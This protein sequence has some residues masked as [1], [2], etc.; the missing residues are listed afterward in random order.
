MIIL[1][2]LKRYNGRTERELQELVIKVLYSLNHTLFRSA[3]LRR[4]E[5]YSSRGSF[6][7][8]DRYTQ[9]DIDVLCSVAGLDKFELILLG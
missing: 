1:D 2:E 7:R 9:R 8:T 3:G 5:R 6:A 4:M